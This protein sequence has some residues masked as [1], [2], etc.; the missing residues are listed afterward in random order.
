MDQETAV[1]KDVHDNPG[2]TAPEI[3]KRLNMKRT[4]TVQALL[5]LEQA[6]GV[7]RGGPRL[8][9]VAGISIATWFPLH[10]PA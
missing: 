1:S 8:C 2:T 10:L 3:A 6:G 7:T 9:R 4:E 5:D